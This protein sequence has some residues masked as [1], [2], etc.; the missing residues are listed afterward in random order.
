M[1]KIL[2]TLIAVIAVGWNTH[3][4]AQQHTIVIPAVNGK[5]EV[6]I[7]FEPGVA[8]LNLE[9]LRAFDAV[10]NA[11]PAVEPQIALNPSLVSKA[12]YVSQHPALKQFLDKYPGAA[13]EIQENPGNYVSP[14]PASTWDRSIFKDGGE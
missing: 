5:P 14:L 9:Q 7:V 13:A 11:D 2:S 4:L 10:R 8:N 3:A 1:R 12:D 6:T